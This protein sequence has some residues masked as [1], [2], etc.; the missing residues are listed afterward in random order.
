MIYDLRRP[1]AYG[2]APADATLA[3]DGNPP[4]DP[5]SGSADQQAGAP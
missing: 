3:E 1:G 5:E 2:L 4:G